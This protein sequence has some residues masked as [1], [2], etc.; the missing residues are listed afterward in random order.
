MTIAVTCRSCKTT[1]QVKDEHAGKRGKCPRCQA[2]VEVPRPP[3]P[4]EKSVPPSRHPTT[5]AAHLIMQEILDAFRGD[6]QPV[7]KTA[8]YG[9][10]IL[11]L[12]V[13]MLVLPT[14]YLLLVSGFAYLLYFH[15]TSNLD[16][17]LHMRHWL[18][19]LFLYIGPLVIGVIL[20]FFM[21]KP[22]FARKS[23][24]QKLR[25]LEFGAEPLLFALVTRVAQ[26]VG[27]PQPK[28]IDID[29]EVN[30]S[31]SFGSALG[32]VLGGDLV[33]TIGLPLVAGLSMEQLAGVIAHELGH[34][35]QGMG[36]RL[37]YVVRS[38]NAWFARIVYERE[39]WDEA[40]V[41]GCEQNEGWFVLFL[42][43]VLF[44]IWLTRWVF[45]LLMA[46]GHAL[47]CFLLRQM[48]YDADRYEARLA[49]SEVF[50]ETARKI[51][52]LQLATNSSYG[53]A[54]VSWGKS[55]RLPDDLS[56]LI[57]SIASCIPA[58]DFR[59]NEKELEKSKTGFFDSH[60]AHGERLAS[61][62][63]EKASGI[64]HLEGP[65]TQLFQDFAKLS[66]TITLKY[67]RNVIGKRATRDS[68][69][70]VVV[71]LDSAAVRGGT[72]EM[73]AEPSD[74]PIPLCD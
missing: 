69:V 41:Q 72:Q 17:I 44:C 33:L 22:L 8:A 20:L 26:A 38:L 19:L 71:F 28:R 23:R 57:L 53:L 48:E 3:T 37:S 6:I 11:V 59:K 61:V 9:L 5:R 12:A 74:A 36:M 63:R 73:S 15:A 4:D 25:T 32:V 2:V 1:V 64:F 43:L 21:V 30:A 27:A 13:A 40:L 42:Y 50:A 51:L 67:F 24:K 66:R 46:I 54:A 29:C 55:E 45:W 68:L 10:G 18:A 60:P 65:A 34:F 7:K 56:A 14:L 58:K 47:S 35:S 62:R 52:L 31:A 16:A 70:P 49:G 39:D